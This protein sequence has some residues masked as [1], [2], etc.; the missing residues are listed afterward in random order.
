[1]NLRILQGTPPHPIISMRNGCEAARSTW[2]H[3]P[4]R[5]RPRVTS[6]VDYF[7]DSIT[8]HCASPIC[9][10]PITA[11]E[12]QHASPLWQWRIKYKCCKNRVCSLNNTVGTCEALLVFPTPLHLGR[13]SLLLENAQHA[14][15]SLPF[16]S[17][18][19]LPRKDTPVG[20]CPRNSLGFL[21]K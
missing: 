18:P 6:G 5:T 9:S 11:A 12:T 19:G 2:L 13:E 4:P 10:S 14:P 15:G 17:Y 16:P 20:L 8:S 1:M 3:S 21:G 7:N